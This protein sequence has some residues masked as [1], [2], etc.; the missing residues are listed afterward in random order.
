MDKT[1]R[2]II[3][4]GT[5]LLGSALVSALAEAGFANVLSIGSKDCDLRNWEATRQFFADHPCDQLVHLAAQAYGIMGNANNKGATFLNNV[6]INTH[7][8]E[9]AR[10]AGVKKITAMGSG[11]VY[12]HPPPA[13]PLREEHIWLGPLHGS[14]DSYGH[15]KR[16]MLA[17]LVAYKEQYDLPFAFVISGNHYGPHDLFDIEQGHVVPAL[18]RKFY[19]AKTNGTKVTVWGTGIAQ[20]D[21]M[22]SHDVA[23]GLIAI[24]DGVEGSVNLGT[25]RAEAIREAIDILAEF[26]GLQDRVVWDR[27]KPD[28][29]EYSA[30]DVSKLLAT[31]YRPQISLKDGLRSTYDWYATHAATARKLR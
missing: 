2:I 9:A 21:F 12:P 28:G 27:T 7:C 8:I 23:R 10:L 26:T 18:I 15:A 14:E 30:Y 13:R 25:G 6:L 4:G 20:R 19:E 24:M 11:C 16:A 29:R 5:G 3:T 17:Q 31:G 1:D 22:H